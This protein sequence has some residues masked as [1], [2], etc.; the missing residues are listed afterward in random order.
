MESENKNENINVEVKEE[1]ENNK[2]ETNTEVKEEDKGESIS[3]LINHEV[4]KK[5]IEMGYSKNVAE[6][7]TF[8]NQNSIDKALEWIYE[9]QK[10]PDFEEEL[11]I[12]GQSK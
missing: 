3:H 7:A 2:N 1:E 10:E 5:L 9:N 8:L 4:S 11:R 12:I 6:K